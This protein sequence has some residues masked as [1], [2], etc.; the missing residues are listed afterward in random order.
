MPGTRAITLF[1][2][3]LLLHFF[4]FKHTIICSF[5]FFCHSPPSTPSH[6]SYLFFSLPV[7]GGDEAATP[8]SNDI[9]STRLVVLLSLS[10]SSHL[11]IPVCSVLC[12]VALTPAWAWQASASIPALLVS[13][14]V[15]WQWED[16][17]AR[18]WWM[19]VP[20]ALSFP[21]PDRSHLI[22]FPGLGFAGNGL[23]HDMS[24]TRCLPRERE[25]VP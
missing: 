10:P 21:F 4:F 17:G 15:E 9:Q 6:I 3:V 14:S 16:Q 18:E 19:A 12:L 8:G 2:L 13:V 20:P 25:G 5:L 1:F 23:K 11:S 22:A 24:L 7:A